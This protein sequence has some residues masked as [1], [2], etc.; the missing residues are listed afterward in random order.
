MPA[1]LDRYSPR[2]P[3][4]LFPGI[5][6]QFDRSN[7]NHL[8]IGLVN[9]M[10]DGALEATENQF[11]TLLNSAADGVMVRLR[12]YA[13]PDVPRSASGRQQIHSFYSPI[14]DLWDRHLD[15]L[16]ITGTKPRA[17]N[18]REEPYWASMS[19]LFEWAQHN[20]HST[21]C[22]C[23]AA[24]AAVL[25]LDGIQRQRLPEKRFGLF[26]CS[27]VADHHLMS[28]MPARFPMPHSRYN[29]LPENEL[30]ACGYSILTR[31]REA[32]VDAF[33]KHGESLFV[34]FQSH[35]EY[36]ADT[37]LREY[38]RDLGRYF[39]GRD[40]S[41]PLLPRGYFEPEVAHTIAELRQRALHN[42][43]D[44][45]STGF[46]SALAGSKLTNRWH[47]P[48]TRIYGNWLEYLRVRK[49]QSRTKQP[50]RI[51]PATWLSDAFQSS[52]LRA[53]STGPDSASNS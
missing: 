23:L 5:D 16:I 4:K 37:L 46:K 35:P 7:A 15:G 33:A 13:L 43:G 1:Y 6:A 39:S 36:H 51:L 28:A 41:L 26:E 12:L 11:T 49:Q 25:H 17:S 8:D 3:W 31:S 48:A 9:N 40:D 42:S 19:R 50:D 38:T 2:E 32:G 22:S 29:D 18:L 47:S 34:F 44:D 52:R 20:T 27:P 14:E 45:L 30:R 10:P 53:F 24:H 21:I